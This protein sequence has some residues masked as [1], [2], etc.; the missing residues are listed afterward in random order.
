MM[1]NV[2]LGWWAGLL[3]GILLFRWWRQTFLRR[4]RERFEGDATA[5][6]KCKYLEDMVKY[7]KLVIRMQEAR[8][9]LYLPTGF[10]SPPTTFT[11][12]KLTALE[13]QRQ[14]MISKV[15]QDPQQLA[16]FRENLTL[17]L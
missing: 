2:D 15:K 12:P 8:K 5:D 4:R 14:Y 11:S 3:I 7:L 16:F 10:G 6:Q 17:S 9:E 13:K 1:N